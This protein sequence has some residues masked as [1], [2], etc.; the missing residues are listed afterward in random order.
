[1]R[2]KAPWRDPHWNPRWGGAA[3]D[4]VWIRGVVR[5]FVSSRRDACY[6]QHASYAS[7]RSQT[8]VGQTPQMRSIGTPAVHIENARKYVSEQSHHIG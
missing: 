2:A 8:P 6:A 1:M 3:M 4:P 7:R 5:V